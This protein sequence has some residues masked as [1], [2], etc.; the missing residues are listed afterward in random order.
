DDASTDATADLAARAGGPKINVI[1]APPLPDGWTGK[2]A[3]L[4][5]GLAHVNQSAAVPDYIWF[6]DADI[7]HAPAVLMRL[8]SKASRDGCDLVS[9]MVRLNCVSAWERLLIP[10]FIF[11]FQ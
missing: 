1:Q 11:F 8:M 5:A 7:V 4:Q 9:L 6:T 10:A 2:L 3:A